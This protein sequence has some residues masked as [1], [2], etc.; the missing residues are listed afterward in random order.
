VTLEFIHPHGIVCGMLKPAIDFC[1][2][3]LEAIWL[4]PLD[5]L[6][7]RFWILCDY[8]GTVTIDCSIVIAATTFVI[9]LVM[10]QPNVVLAV[11]DP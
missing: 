11:V 6:E 9:L 2:E 1:F 4:T 5:I 10:T 8:D 3:A 7:P